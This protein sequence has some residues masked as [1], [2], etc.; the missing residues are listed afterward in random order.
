[1]KELP[2]ALAAIG[3]LVLGIGLLSRPIK[4]TIIPI[5]VLAVGVGVLL[6]PAGLGWL[7]P[8]RWGK[9]ETILEEAARVTL[10]I[11]LMGVALRLP[12]G[13]VTR[14]WRSLVVLIEIGRASCRER[15]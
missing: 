3:I 4:R 9:W 8:H 12:P 13:Y 1:M 10:A 7:D 15:V 14:H 6:S 11:A 2:T 5:P